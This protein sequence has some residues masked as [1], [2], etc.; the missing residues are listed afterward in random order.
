MI[1]ERH[2]PADSAAPAAAVAP[3]DV[4]F[5]PFELTIL[6]HGCNRPLELFIQPLHFKEEVRCP[7]C[8]KQLSPQ[9][10]REALRHLRAA[11]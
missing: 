11:S 9:I 4:W 1:Q 7:R 5:A 6:C 3:E 2:G 8:L 10:R